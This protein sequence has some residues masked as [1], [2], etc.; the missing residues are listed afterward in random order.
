VTEGHGNL[1]MQSYVLTA[2]GLLEI[3]MGRPEQ[4]I[5]W[6]EQVEE[7]A[8]EKAG[9][10]HSSILPWRSD[11]VEAYAMAGRD[12][13]AAAAA[14][15]LAREA[16]L[17]GS[18]VG[19]A[20]AARSRALLSDD[21]SFAELFE[22]ALALESRRPMP[23]ERARTLLLYGARLHRARRR[24]EA[25]QRL[26]EA[27]R[28]FAELGARPWS[29]RVAAELRAAGAR[30]RAVAS[31]QTGELTEQELRVAIALARGM[32]IREAAAALFLSPKT[33][34]S[35]LRQVYAKLDIHSRARLALIATQRGWL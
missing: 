6:L 15:A 17:T 4:A 8:L 1:T 31:V 27:E 29:E 5:E 2:L 33:V 24:A 16:E 26:L 12:A 14:D 20:L 7:V 11:L 19:A 10:L 18:A 23:F 9:L 22:A 21:D 30:R 35:H 32:T 28:I 25:R 13:D 3:G 34:D